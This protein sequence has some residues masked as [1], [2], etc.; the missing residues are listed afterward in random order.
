MHSH[1]HRESAAR[2]L[3]DLDPPTGLSGGR[4]AVPIAPSALW[5][6]GGILHFISTQI[7]YPS[8]MW[9]IWLSN[10][11][12]REVKAPRFEVGRSGELVFLDDARVGH[13]KIVKV[14]ASGIWM[15]VEPA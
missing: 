4:F 11:E 8:P 7:C 2:T 13:G 15:E 12:H 14:L 9:W 5:L 1:T 6:R 3:P 10:G